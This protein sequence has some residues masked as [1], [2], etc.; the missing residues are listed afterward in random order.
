MAVTGQQVYDLALALIDEV[1]TAGA[2]DHSDLS[3]K[4]KAVQFLTILQSEILPT[5]DETAIV[6]D[7]AD[8]LLLPPRDCLLVLPY[9]LAAHLVIQDD[10]ASAS[11]FQQRYEELRKKKRATIGPI[12]S[13]YDTST[14][15]PTD[16][17]ETWD[18]GTF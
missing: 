7:L 2:I 5:A 8:D 3:L 17:G 13:V 12:V 4:A 11:F 9:G 15:N 14:S 16:A 10:P 6:E 18:G 1:T